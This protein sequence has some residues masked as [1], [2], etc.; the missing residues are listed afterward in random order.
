V[1]RNILYQFKRLNSKKANIKRRQSTESRNNAAEK[2]GAGPFLD[3][4]KV[5]EL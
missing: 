4:E 3:P 1:L 5:K 2:L